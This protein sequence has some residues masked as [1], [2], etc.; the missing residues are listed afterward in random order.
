MEIV[1][2]SPIERV[3][4][5]VKVHG[6]DPSI[7]VRRDGPVTA[8]TETGDL[9]RYLERIYAL[10]EGACEEERVDEDTT[11]GRRRRTNEHRYV[12][13][14][15]DEDDEE[16][17]IVSQQTAK[18]D[19]FEEIDEEKD[20]LNI[21]TDKD[22][23]AQAIGKL[24][25]KKAVKFLEESILIDKSQQVVV[26]GHH[27]SVLDEIYAG[28]QKVY[29]AEEIICVDGRTDAIERRDRVD[30]FY[31][32]KS[33]GFEE[34]GKTPSPAKVRVA[35]FGITLAVGI[36]LSSASTV[37]F[38]RVTAKPAD[39]LQAEDRALAKRTQR[40]KTQ[41][42][43]LTFTIVLQKRKDALSIPIVGKD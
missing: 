16:P 14:D 24:K 4:H 21:V 23:E 5:T 30:K 38:R 2:R 41:R 39:L 32:G 6:D 17:I 13:S 7:E 29:R 1:R 34:D 11:W 9:L 12:I 31:G 36:D 15:E 26:F 37:C 10:D 20:D 19:A 42:R 40:S 3:A 8:E 22:G 33:Q 43:V 25:V 28:L 35:V 27:H 18:N